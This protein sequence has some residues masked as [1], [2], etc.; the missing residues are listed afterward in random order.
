[1]T[2]YYLFL[3]F[4]HIFPKV[5]YEWLKMFSLDFLYNAAF[6]SP[7]IIYHSLYD[8]RLRSTSKIRHISLPDGEKHNVIV[9]IHGRGGYP[10]DFQDLIDKL[11]PYTNQ[12][13]LAFHLDN[14]HTLVSEDAIA[15]KECLDPLMPQIRSMKLIGLS[16]GG[17]IAIKYALDLD[18]VKRIITVSSPLNGT[19]MANN[20]P[21]CSNTR[22]ELAYNSECSQKLKEQSKHLDIYSIVPKFDHMIIPIESTYYPHS[23]TY[24][25]KGYYSHAGIIYAPEVINQIKEWIF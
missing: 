4:P 2:L 14:A 23:K 11:Q 1:M 10:S 20:Y 12:K 6:T 25:Y 5:F 13:F 18:R 19:Y 24:F 21:F 8:M 15:L 17:L 7:S 22:K 16:K 3:T 9:C